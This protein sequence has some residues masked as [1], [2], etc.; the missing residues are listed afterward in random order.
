MASIKDI[1]KSQFIKGEDLPQWYEGRLKICSTCDYNSA[2]KKD[3]SLKTKSW[4]LIA[5]K[6]CTKCGC[7]I[8]N[9]AKVETESCPM[10]F[11]EAVSKREKLDLSLVKGDVE[12][13]YNDKRKA[14]LV[15]YGQRQRGF[16][17]TFDLKVKE[18][19]KDL[20]LKSTC[21]CTTAQ[22]NQDKSI[23]SIKYDSNRLGYFSKNIQLTYIKDGNQERTTINITGTV[24]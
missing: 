8:T 20:R 4:E 23:I 5:G 14:Y 7:T 9:K 12:I 10:K 3:K 22:N 16:D 11:W 2:N 13:L 17:S 1:V 18:D 6:H 19:V 15:D 24:K 21:G